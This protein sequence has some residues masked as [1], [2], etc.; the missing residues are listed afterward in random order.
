MAKVSSYTTVTAVADGDKF[1]LAADDGASGFLDRTLD[2]DIAKRQFGAASPIASAPTVNEDSG[3]GYRIGSL[4]LTAAGALYM[5]EDASVG[6]AVWTELATATSAGDVVGPASAV[7]G[8]IATFNGTTGKL[9]QDGGISSATFATAAQGALADTAVQPGDPVTFNPQTGTTYTFALGDEEDFNT[10][11][12]ASPVAV[13]IPANASVAFPVGTVLVCGQKGAGL[14]A[15]T[16]DTGVTVNGAS[17][18][19]VDSAGQ[20]STWTLTKIAT[21]EWW[22]SGGLA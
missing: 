4:V 7:S 5:C 20:W 15:C 6:A 22:A 1:Y 10:F 3:D 16:G 17:A 18:G 8:N 2:G 9:L 12:N 14:V 11:A 13:T 19:S 21:D